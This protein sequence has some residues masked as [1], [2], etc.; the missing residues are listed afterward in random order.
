MVFDDEENGMGEFV[1]VAFV[2]E[3]GAR[4]LMVNRSS[5]CDDAC[6]HFSRFASGN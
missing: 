6:R 4:F 5:Y 3:R 2:N 1:E